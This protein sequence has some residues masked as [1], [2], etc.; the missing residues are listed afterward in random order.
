MVLDAGCNAT[1]TVP[2][3]LGRTRRS[4]TA[5]TRAHRGRAARR[6]GYIAQTGTGR[7]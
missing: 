3:L 4:Q 2:P 1:V 7:S 5:H 6:V